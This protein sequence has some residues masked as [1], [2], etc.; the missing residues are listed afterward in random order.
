GDD[1]QHAVG[2][3]RARL[4]HLVGIHGEV[5]AQ[6]R[7]RAGRARLPQ[8]GVAALEEIHV[9]EHRQAGRAARLVAACDRGRIEVRADHALRRTRLLR[10]GDHRRRPLRDRAFDRGREATRRRLVGGARFELAQGQACAALGHFRDLARQDPLQHGHAASRARRCVASTNSASL[11][12]A[13]PEAIASRARRMPS[14]MSSATPATYSAAPAL[15]ATI[16]SGRPGVFSSAESNIACDSAGLATRRLRVWAMAMPKSSG[17][18]SYSRTWPSRSSP[19]IVAAPSDSSSMPSRPQTT[20]A[21]VA[22]S[23]RSTR[24]WIPTRSGWNTP[25]RIDGAPA[26]LVSG[27]RMLNRVRTPSSRRTGATTFIAGWCTGAYMK[28]APVSAMQ[29]ATLS[30]SNSIAA[31]SASSTSAAPDFEDTLR[32]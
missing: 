16:S 12:R 31:P 7:Q 17:C 10:F 21:R 3:E 5:L 8:E 22:P 11:A 27:P 32:L 1:Q 18:T 25:I 19:T 15:S 29:R 26:G 20:S 14:A 24:T 30:G 2:A 28:P 9:G 6:H 13:A 23:S 4:D